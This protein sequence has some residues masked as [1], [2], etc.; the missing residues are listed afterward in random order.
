MPAAPPEPGARRARS[1][2]TPL[3]VALGVVVAAVGV[4][5]IVGWWTDGDESPD[6]PAVAPVGTADADSPATTQATGTTGGAVADSTATTPAPRTETVEG[7]EVVGRG[8]SASE[9]I[10]GRVGSYGVVIENT[11]DAPAVFLTVHVAVRDGTGAVVA[12]NRHRVTVVHPGTRFGVGAQVTGPMT[13]DIDAL[14]VSIDAGAGPLPEG[15]VSA[16]DVS[17][18]SDE[19]GTYTSFVASSS[20]AEELP[21]PRVHVVYRNARGEIVGGDRGPVDA[22]EPG[23]RTRGEVTS[24]DRIPRVDR[25][26]VYV[27]PGLF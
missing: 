5:L 13:D 21:E 17:T 18:S 19:F 7:I 22:I 2:R 8:F 6:P 3:V 10:A 25:A 12:S 23:G 14:D 1:A 11:N 4:G 9:G 27:D 15:A 16:T 20:Y 26:E 24:Y